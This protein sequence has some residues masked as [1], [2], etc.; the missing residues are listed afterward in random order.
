MSRETEKDKEDLANHDDAWNEC[1]TTTQIEHQTALSA[2]LFPG[3]S[4]RANITTAFGI[5]EEDAGM[6]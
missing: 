4:C 3:F 6:P 1:R 2:S 5:Q